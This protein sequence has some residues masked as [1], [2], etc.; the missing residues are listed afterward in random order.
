MVE[1]YHLPFTHLLEN[2]LRFPIQK[3]C[4]V[5]LTALQ[6]ISLHRTR[7]MLGPRQEHKY[8]QMRGKTKGTTYTGK[9]LQLTKNQGNALFLS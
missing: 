3:Q 9:K 1:V 6:Q 4:F 5:T 7:P 2:V 8:S